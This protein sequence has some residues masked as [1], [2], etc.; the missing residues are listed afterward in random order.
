MPIRPPDDFP[1]WRKDVDRKLGELY[2]M[3]NSRPALTTVQGAPIVITDDAGTTRQIIGAQP[4]G[5]V[6]TIDQNGAPP[7]APTAPTVTPAPLGIVVAWDGT[8]TDVTPADFDHV[9]IHVSQTDGFAPDSTTLQGT[10]RHAGSFPVAPLQA[11][12]AYFARLVAVNTSGIAGGASAQA[13]G[14]PAEVV[15]T[16]IVDGIVTTLKLADD[17]VTQAKIAAGAIGT[18]ELAANSVVAGKIAANAVDTSQ[19]VAGSVQTA[20]IAAGAVQADQIAA[21]AITTAKLEALAVTAAKIAANTITAGQIASGSITADL[22]ASTLVLASEIIAGNPAGARVQIDSDGIN[23]YGP[24][25]KSTV[26]IGADGNASFKGSS[27]TAGNVTAS[28]LA[29]NAAGNGALLLYG[30]S[31]VELNANPDFATGITSWSTVSGSVTYSADKPFGGHD[32]M[33]VTNATGLGQADSEFVAVSPNV[34]YIADFLTMAGP[35]GVPMVQLHF[36]D[37]SHNLL[38]TLTQFPTASTTDWVA[39]SIVATAPAGAAFAKLSAWSF[40]TNSLAYAAR[41]A[42]SGSEISASLAND[43]GV[44]QYGNPYPDGL[45]TLSVAADVGNFTTLDA[46]E[47]LTAGKLS[48]GNFD[49]GEN[50]SPTGTGGAI[51]IP[52]HLGEIA[53]SIQITM[54]SSANPLYKPTISANTAA[55]FTVQATRTDTGANGL[56]GQPFSF[57]WEVRA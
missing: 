12:T 11:G 34:T 47:T 3:A 56:S 13:S 48:A 43:S 36:Y 51:T 54:L 9:E 41:A 21:N 22:L 23:A 28:N 39:S 8:L 45:S 33:K 52:H 57:Y 29:V 55:S 17:A 4:D 46:T 31:D 38:D 16:S 27:V 30:L 19:L 6:T 32:T 37:A 44:D 14:T 5:S 18:D 25:G 20:T 40:A 10:V 26:M 7:P 15:A 2:G 53:R 24:D 50:T 49:C 35:F 42:I 1:Q